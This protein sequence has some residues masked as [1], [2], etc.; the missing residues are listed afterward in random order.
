MLTA[1][2]DTWASRASLGAIADAA[3]FTLGGIGYVLKP[4]TY[5]THASL[6]AYDP[7]TDSWSERA[8]FPAPRKAAAGFAIGGIGYISGGIEGSTMMN[9]LWAY[10]PGT[11]SWSAKAPMPGLPRTYAVSFS[12]GDKG[13]I[14]GGEGPFTA[15]NDLNEYDPV[16]NTWI[17]RASMTDGSIGAGVF[18]IAGRAYVCFSTGAFLAYDP[19]SD[20]WTPRTPMPPPPGGALR[21][22]MFS[23][24]A[25]G[26]GFAGGGTQNFIDFYHDLNE[27]SPNT[28]SWTHRADLDAFTGYQGFDLGIDDLGYVGLPGGGSWRYEPTPDLV[29][30][31]VQTFYCA[32]T[33]IGF[34]CQVLGGIY[35]PG[36]VFTIQLSDASGSFG[37]PV[38]IG[39]STITAPGVMFGTIP[40]NTPP[41]N[42]YRVRVISDHPARVGPA[43]DAD[44]IVVAPPV[45]YRDIDGDGLGDPNDHVAT[46]N[47]IPTGYVTN[48]SDDCPTLFGVVGNSCD[49]GIAETDDDRITPACQCH[50]LYHYVLDIVTD[51]HGEETTWEVVKQGTN[52]VVSSGP[53]TAYGNNQFFAS[54]I[55]VRGEDCFELRVHDA[56][57]NGINGGGYVLLDPHGNP[58]IDDDG[59]GDF[60]ALSTISGG[61]GFC[62]PTGTDRL[63]DASCNH[64]DWLIDDVMRAQPVPLVSAQFGI[65]NQSDDGYQ[66]WFFAPNGGYSRRIFRDHATSGGNGEANAI[67]ATKLK[68]TSIVM[69]PLPYEVL[70]NVRVRSKVN[71]VFAPFGPACRFKLTHPS[72]CPTTQL[73]DDPADPHFSCGVSKNLFGSDKVWAKAVTRPA[74]GGV[75]VANRYQFEWTGIDIAYTR[76]IASSNAALVLGVWATNPLTPCNWYNVRVRA[77]FDG[78]ATY[79][80]YGNNCTVFIDGTHCGKSVEENGVATMHEIDERINVYP[81]PNDGEQLTLW[82]PAFNSAERA[83]VTVYD[84]AGRPV[85]NGAQVLNLGARNTTLVFDHPL[86]AGMYV[87][88]LRVAS[89][90]LVKRFLVR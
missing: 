64:G 73:Q 75:Q 90:R 35:E 44:I 50:G 38:T 5:P 80:P 48:S 56:G 45:Y 27:Y 53:F 34:T 14:G 61:Q 74:P 16:T 72:D 2:P 7:G 49:D 46:C 77:S 60:G 42:G 76:T 63:N 8:S 3:T 83:E 25:G 66:F 15:M 52:T 36:N 40:A 88:E 47:G 30:S 62:T 12:I 51:D 86:M 1:Q 57:G 23:F 82:S 43:N 67:R 59:N 31:V 11:D 58:V 69:N 54:P 87:L 19:V 10:D 68:L 9:D 21:T 6:W 17:P 18:T 84:L 41:G 26:R 24:S 89:E 32:G 13:Y 81:D 55:A 20:T 4:E 22:W 39:T 65:G 79:C 78:G 71:G 70:L 29:C 85:W 33:S 28:D 37:S